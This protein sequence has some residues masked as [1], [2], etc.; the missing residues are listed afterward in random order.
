MSKYVDFQEVKEV[1]NPNEKGYDTMPTNV[2]KDIEKIMGGN[3]GSDLKKTS[4]VDMRATLV[5][6]VLG[7]GVSMYKGW[8]IW[9]GVVV[10]ALIGGVINKNIKWQRTKCTNNQ[11]LLF[12][13]TFG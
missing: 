4:A 10:G 6:A 3:L 5:G 12:L 9:L 7:G 8:R 2:K 11:G 13:L 1:E